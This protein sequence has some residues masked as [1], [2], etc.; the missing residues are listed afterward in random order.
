MRFKTFIIFCGL[1]AMVCELTGCEAFNRKFTRKPKKS[2]QSVEMV[3]APEEYK[4][5]QMSKEELYRQYL[6]FWRSWQDE[7]INTLVQN[8]SYKKK[9]DCTE[10]AVK[11]LIGMRGMLDE[12]K[13]RQLDIYLKQ[14]TDLQSSFKSD[15]YGASSSNYRQRVEGVR[16]N[17]LEKFSYS[18][19][20]NDL[21]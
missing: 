10:Q 16:R 18:D 3:L 15:V 4:G 20:K 6:L 14:M 12:T 1:L 8:T 7:L 21:R 17:I 11:N 13:Q 5:P 19:I 2:D 9:N